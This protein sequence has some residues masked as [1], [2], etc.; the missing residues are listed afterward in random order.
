[1]YFAGLAMSQQHATRPRGRSAG[2]TRPFRERY[3]KQL[4][5]YL[6]GHAASSASSDAASLRKGGEVLEVHVRPKHSL[7][8]IEKHKRHK[9][10]H[11]EKEDASTDTA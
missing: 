10:Q 9:R 2:R 5:G 6:S 3:P 7:A 1:V 4:G 11:S 8:G